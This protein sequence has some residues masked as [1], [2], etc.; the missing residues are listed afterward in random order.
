[1]YVCH[2]NLIL[3]IF[4]IKNSNTHNNNKLLCVSVIYIF[5][6]IM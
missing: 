2:L 1:M 5:V 4:K 6:I 3:G